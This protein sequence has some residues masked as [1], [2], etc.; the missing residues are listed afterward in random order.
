MI[1][2]KSLDD[3]PISNKR[4]KQLKRLKTFQSISDGKDEDKII[5]SLT[6]KTVSEKKEKIKKFKYATGNPLFPVGTAEINNIFPFDLGFSMTV[7]KAQG[8]TIQKVILNLTSHPT[9]ESQMEFAAIFVAC[10]E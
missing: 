3:K 5:I 1:I 4:K 9:H 6:K 2:L 7:H 10:P 8:C